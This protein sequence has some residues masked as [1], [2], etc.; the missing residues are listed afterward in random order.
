MKNMGD[1]MRKILASIDIGSDLIKLVVGEVS[2]NG[3]VNILAAAHVP[4]LGIKKGFVVNPQALLPK[5]EEVFNKCEDMIGLRIDK[6]V[7]SVPSDNAEFF[8]T[9]GS[10]TI[11]NDE[12]M[13]K[14]TDIIRAMQASTYNKIN[15]SREIVS[16]KPTGYFIDDER[17]TQNPVGQEAVKLTVKSLVATVPKKNVYTLEKCLEKIG[18]KVIDYSVGSVGD[19][20]EFRKEMMKEVVGVIINIGYMTT[21]VS[22]FNKGLLTNTITIDT[23]AYYIETDL[24]YI[25]KLTL[26]TAKDVKLNLA[27]AHKR[28]V[29]ASIKKK[30]QTKNNEIVDISE[31]E[32]TEVASSRVEEILKLAK[33]QINL[34]TKKEIHY[35]MITGGVSEMP[36]FNLLLE[37]VFGHSA[38]IGQTKEIG[39][40]SNI[41]SSSV[42]L[43]KYYEEK[44]RIRKQE[45]SI[46]NENETESLGSAPKKSFGDNS[47]LGKLFGY[48]FDN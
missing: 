6:V 7:L 24:S 47:I 11:N 31:Y 10:T 5:L 38:K 19:Y 35:I 48:F 44:L 43:I 46:F 32:A 8:L 30:Y 27:S 37:E 16:I 45:F 2:K 33:K 34:L 23:G 9:E 42:G 12:H 28:G 15:E 14:E 13:I 40:R 18:V 17:S 20:Y 29:S 39:V 21:T 25:F 36:N 3:K 41:Y 1:E 4:S 26:N 22:I